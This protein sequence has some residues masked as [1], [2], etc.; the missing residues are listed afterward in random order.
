MS[1]PSF[2]QQQ[3]MHMFGSPGWQPDLTVPTERSND[4]G[5]G[6]ATTTNRKRKREVE[7]AAANARSVSSST[8]IGD[9]MVVVG[10]KKRK[11]YDAVSELLLTI[12]TPSKLPYEIAA[13]I[14]EYTR[15]PADQM[16]KMALDS[17]C[18]PF[19]ADQSQKAT[20]G[21]P[22][23]AAFADVTHLDLSRVSIIM[24]D[25]QRYNRDTAYCSRMERLV[26]HAITQYY[27]QLAGFTEPL[28][29]VITYDKACLL[30]RFRQLN[31][32]SLRT[33]LP[34]HP[35]LRLRT[36]QGPDS[37]SSSSNSSSSSSSSSKAGVSL[38][39]H[40]CTKPVASEQ[41]DCRID[42][43][44]GVIEYRGAIQF[45]AKACWPQ[46]GLPGITVEND[47]PEA[48]AASTVAKK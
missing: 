17:I 43:N 45:T 5:S 27:P 36:E 26:G 33:C 40:T 20:I 34:K 30:P 10:N 1:V 29:S 42:L 24:Y 6:A 46:D 11:V 38:S 47:C 4:A 13:L 7:A 8:V 23:A 14:R 37:N 35:E 25:K 32:F 9:Q 12:D 22:L 44:E 18:L 15:C 19:F 3:S 48:Q 39:N 21:A 41:Y 2:L 28:E 31:F 16:I